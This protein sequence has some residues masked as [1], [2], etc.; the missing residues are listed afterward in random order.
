[1]YVWNNFFTW[2]KNDITFFSPLLNYY[3]LQVSYLN[4]P[5]PSQSLVPFSHK[6]THSIEFRIKKRENNRIVLYKTY[7]I[8]F[9]SISHHIEPAEELRGILFYS[10]TTEKK[11]YTVLLWAERRRVDGCGSGWWMWWMSDLSQWLIVFIKEKTKGL[12]LPIT[13]YPKVI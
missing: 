5:K 11:A 1:M 8:D 10:I 9:L 6:S 7:L 12:I 3:L 13:G 2:R 4:P